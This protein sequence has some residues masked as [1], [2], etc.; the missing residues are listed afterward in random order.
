MHQITKTNKN[1]PITK[2][3]NTPRNNSN[4]N[5]HTLIAKIEIHLINETEIHLPHMCHLQALDHSY[6]GTYVELILEGHR[7]R[8]ADQ[9][10]STEFIA[11]AIL[12]L[13]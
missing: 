9:R 1:S 5:S 3:Q 12:L 7:G 8:R 2:T 13:C 11:D 4:N 10:P 6:S